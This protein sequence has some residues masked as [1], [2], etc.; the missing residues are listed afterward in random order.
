M[1]EL[2]KDDKERLWN[3]INSGWDVIKGNKSGDITK[4]K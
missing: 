4:A 2:T 3:N 1:T